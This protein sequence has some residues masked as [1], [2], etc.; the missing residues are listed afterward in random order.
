MTTGSKADTIPD[1]FVPEDRHTRIPKG[2]TEDWS[3]GS[4]V[5]RLPAWQK[6]LD[7]IPN[8]AINRK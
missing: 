4:V 7:V 6:A 8:A 5:E 2:C 3:Y 1:V